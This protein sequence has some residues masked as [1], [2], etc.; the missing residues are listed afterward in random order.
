MSYHGLGI[1]NSV[2]N[3]LPFELHVPGYQYCGPGTRLKKRLARGDPG[4]NPLDTACKE[5]D[6]AYS[7]YKE[8]LDKRHRADK[9][10]QEAAWKRVKS[11]DATLG[12]KS[13]ALLVTGAMKLKRKLGMGLKKK[14]R[15]VK[16]VALRKG[17]VL[18]ARTALKQLKKIKNLKEGA[19][20]ALSAARMAVKTV[21]GRKRVRAPRII[22][23]SKQGGI[24][25]LL[26]IFAGLSALGTLA[27]G[28]AGIVT[29]VNKTKNAQKQLDEAKRHNKTIESVLLGKKGGG[30]YLQPHRQGLG[31]YLKPSTKNY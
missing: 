15:K 14:E 18:K 8:N 17:I 30:L 27:G 19:K 7:N 16:K 10:L 21:G 5:H 24:L 3:K 22:P 28:A 12:E 4:K 29:A 23:I 31:L 1:V 13:V 11:S 9:L 6:I 2:I 26:P 25:P 20:I